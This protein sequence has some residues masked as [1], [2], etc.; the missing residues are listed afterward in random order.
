MNAYSSRVDTHWHWTVLT[1][2]G[3]ALVL[4]TASQAP[5]DERAQPG[6]RVSSKVSQLPVRLRTDHTITTIWDQICHYMS[7]FYLLL[8]S[9]TATLAPM[10]LG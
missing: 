5:S 7:L 2:W 1:S 9:Q 3:Y 4:T 8:L 10:R 6:F